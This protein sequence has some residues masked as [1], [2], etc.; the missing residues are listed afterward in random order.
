MMPISRM[1][2]V[3]IDDSPCKTPN[4]PLME[5]SID[6]PMAAEVPTD[7]NLPFSEAQD[8]LF[9]KDVHQDEASRED[10][11]SLFAAA[12]SN[13]IFSN[14]CTLA[15]TT[16][17]TNTCTTA[18]TTTNTLPATAMATTSTNAAT[19]STRPFIDKMTLKEKS[20]DNDDLVVTAD[21]VISHF[22]FAGVVKQQPHDNDDGD[23]DASTVPYNL[24]EE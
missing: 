9:G 14:T 6:P 16:T 10:E 21:A 20:N 22:E 3:S 4:N 18:T 15:A 12:G 7:T 8:N 11:D 13:I 1:M 5:A 2:E 23:D 24:D 19:T 17:N